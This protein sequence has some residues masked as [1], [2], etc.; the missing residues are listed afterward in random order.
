MAKIYT[1]IFSFFVFAITPF[2][3]HAATLGFSPSSVSRTAG[4]TFTVT[5]SVSSADTAI[6]AVS[7]VISFPTNAL[8]VAGI[9]KTGSIISLWVQ[10]PSFSNSQGT[11]TFEGIALNP[12]Y[13]GSG[14]TI[15]AVT[16]RTKTAGSATLRFSSSS[17]LANDGVGTNVLTGSGSASI[18]ILPVAA[19]Q[20]SPKTSSSKA[21]AEKVSTTTESVALPEIPTVTSYP[22]E[23]TVDDTVLVK[24][25]AN[26]GVD[27]VVTLTH[28]G[29]VIQE[30]KSRA[31]GIGEFTTILGPL[32]ETGDYSFTVHAI[33]EALNESQMSPPFLVVVKEGW[34]TTIMNIVLKYLSLTALVLFT[35]AG[36]AIAS[37]FVWY[38]FI[39]IIRRMRREAREA[40]RAS[41]K[42]FK[43]LR[44]SVDR[45]IARLKNTKRKLTSEELAFL[46]EF[47]EKLGEAEEMVAKEIKDISES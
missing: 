36:I 1:I 42:A 31:T 44:T 10:E 28:S 11:V 19:P 29:S 25:V 22:S 2:F 47:S 14:G 6:N 30:Q 32:S 45:H 27:V 4:S 23:V 33:D 24:G 17:V 18:S 34:L 26:P 39:G 40:E 46:E 12:G 8:E 20:E 13:Q 43:I 5:V 16:F 3:A 38:R 37:V 15:I 7:G 9:S 41:E 35:L 21:A